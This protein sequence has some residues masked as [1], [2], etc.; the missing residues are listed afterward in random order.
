MVIVKGTF[1]ISCEVKSIYCSP[2]FDDINSSITIHYKNDKED[3]VNVVNFSRYEYDD[4]KN[5]VTVWLTE[6]ILDEEYKAFDVLFISKDEQPI[7]DVDKVEKFKEAI[8]NQIEE[9][10]SSTEKI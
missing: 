3:V 10:N 4:K 5:I 1:S 7:D 8:D 9:I 2:P 6:N